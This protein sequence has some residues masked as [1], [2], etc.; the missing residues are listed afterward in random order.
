[1]PVARGKPAEHTVSVRYTLERAGTASNI[2]IDKDAPKELGKAVAAWLRGCT[3]AAGPGVQLPAE[4]SESF[5]FS[6]AR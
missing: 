6:P 2:V 3:W 5:H 1:M 4:L